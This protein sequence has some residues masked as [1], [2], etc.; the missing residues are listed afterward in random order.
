[1]PEKA[2]DFNRNPTGECYHALHTS[3]NLVSAV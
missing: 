1:M 2:L 3:A